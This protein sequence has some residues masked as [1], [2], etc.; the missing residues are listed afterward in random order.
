MVINNDTLND[1]NKHFLGGDI[2]DDSFLHYIHV[3]S[4]IQPKV[5]NPLQFF[6]IFI[7]GYDKWRRKW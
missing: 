6:L 2:A 4:L 5:N 7:I 3:L 1:T